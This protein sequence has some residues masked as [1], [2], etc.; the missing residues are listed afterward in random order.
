MVYLVQRDKQHMSA[1]RRWYTIRCVSPVGQLHDTNFE[2]P[3]PPAAKAMAA[4]LR[5]IG[6]TVQ[7]NTFQ[8]KPRGVRFMAIMRRHPVGTGAL[9]GSAA[10]LAAYWWVYFLLHVGGS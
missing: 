9:A 8:D 7:I 2:I 10:G 6:W 3:Y 1:P 5:S 4:Q